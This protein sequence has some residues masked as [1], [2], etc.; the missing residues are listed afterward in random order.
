VLAQRSQRLF[1]VRWRKANL[2]VSKPGKTI[3]LHH[4]RKPMRPS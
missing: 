2:T 1:A 3:H 4:R